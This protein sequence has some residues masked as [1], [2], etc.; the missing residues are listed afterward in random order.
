MGHG[1][2]KI[3]DADKHKGKRYSFYCAKL[4]AVEYGKSQT[5]FRW[6]LN[7]DNAFSGV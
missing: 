6:N 2:Q 5:Q 3:D 1:H 7:A 4:Y